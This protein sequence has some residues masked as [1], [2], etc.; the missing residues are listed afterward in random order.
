MEDVLFLVIG[1]CGLTMIAAFVLFLTRKPAGGGGDGGVAGEGQEPRA[2]REHDDDEDIAALGFVLTDKEYDEVCALK[3][4][5]KKRKKLL[6]KFAKKHA[7]ARRRQEELEVNEQRRTKLSAY[8]ERQ[9]QRE[10]EREEEEAR[11]EAAAAKAKAEEEAALQEQY[12]EWSGSFET[13][14]QGAENEGEDTDSKLSAFVERIEQKKVVLLSDLSIEFGL[15]SQAAVDRVKQLEEEGTITGVIDD[16]G[17]FIY[18]SSDELKK[19]ADMVRRRGRISVS[20]LVREIN[21]IVDLNPGKDDN[22]D[23]V[24][25]GGDDGSK[26]ALEN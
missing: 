12:D 14:E 11:R 26:E 17:K 1:L 5:G 25:D 15:S 13:T 16:R 23:N 10:K 3:E 9:A 7:R 24:E 18:V 19:I 22:D 2:H 6:A 21:S 4:G 8:E 20:E